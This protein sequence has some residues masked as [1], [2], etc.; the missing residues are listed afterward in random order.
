MSSGIQ[1]AKTVTETVLF[2]LKP[3]HLRKLIKIKICI[4]P[5]DI[6][7]HNKN[8]KHSRKNI[9]NIWAPWVGGTRRRRD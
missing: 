8:N 2:A 6:R 4:L 1:K 3:I 7:M 9:A 5:V